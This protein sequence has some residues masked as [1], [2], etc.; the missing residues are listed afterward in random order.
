MVFNLC[1]QNI[2]EPYN[3]LAAHISSI[4]PEFGEVTHSRVAENSYDG[5]V[6]P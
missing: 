1:S 6:S 2:G 4:S 3:S 5:M